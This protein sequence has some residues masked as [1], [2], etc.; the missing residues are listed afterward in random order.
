MRVSLLGPDISNG[1]GNGRANGSANGDGRRKMIVD[2]ECV[3]VVS[4]GGFIAGGPLT[5]VFSLTKYRRHLS[6]PNRSC[7]YVIIN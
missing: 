5:L 7:W 6:M 3:A 2:N 4:C 1:P